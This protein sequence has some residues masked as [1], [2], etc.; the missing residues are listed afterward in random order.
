MNKTV[1]LLTTE[2]ISHREAEAKARRIEE[3]EQTIV[4]A[5]EKYECDLVYE[6]HCINGVIAEAR[7]ICKA[8]PQTH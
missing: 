6:T 8:R 4:A 3:C 1:P 2:A 7:F 5:L